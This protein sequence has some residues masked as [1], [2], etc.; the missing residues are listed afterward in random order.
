M[1]C[2]TLRQHHAALVGRV[3]WWQ[4]HAAL[5]GRAPWWQ[6]HNCLACG[7]LA[8]DLIP[9]HC[10]ANTFGDFFLHLL[11]RNRSLPECFQ[12]II[13]GNDPA[14]FTSREAPE[15]SVTAGRAGLEDAAQKKNRVL[16]IGI[17]CG[18]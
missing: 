16:F 18:E 3:P 8:H 5:V 14:L 1:L 6:Y 9:G 4:Y 13:A 12:Y 7:T 17:T 15:D 2:C 10:P 11:Q